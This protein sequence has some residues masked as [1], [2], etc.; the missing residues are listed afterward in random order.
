MSRMPRDMR[1]KAASFMPEYST[2]PYSE[3]LTGKHKRTCFDW[4]IDWLIHSFIDGWID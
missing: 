2:P 1:T 3:S 4:I